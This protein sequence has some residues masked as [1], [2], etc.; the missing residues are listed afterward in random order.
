MNNHAVIYFPKRYLDIIFFAMAICTLFF[1]KAV[2]AEQYKLKLFLDLSEFNQA[3]TDAVWLDPLISPTNGGFFV[4]QDNGLI[5]LTGKD[6]KINRETILDLSQ[7]VN[8]SAFTSLT[9]ITLHP[10]FM[11]PEQ[12]GYATL[13]TAHTTDFSPQKNNNRLTLD[14]ADIDFSFETVITAW[15]YDFDDQ[16]I[17]QQTQREVLRIPIKNLD[18]AIQQLTFDP[19]QKSW[20]ADYGQLHFSLKYENELKDHPLYSGAILRI[21]PL[22]FGARNYTVPRTNPFIKDPKINNEI[23]VLGGQNI[24]HFFWAKN[25]HGVIFIQHNNIEEYRLSKAKVGDNLLNP[26]QS[27]LLWQQTSAMSSML[28]YQGRNFLSL[29]NKMVFFKLL[30]NQWYLSSLALMPL[31]NDLPVFEKLI[32][33][34]ALSPNSHLN[35]HQDNRGEIILFDNHKSKMYSLQSTHSNE[36]EVNISPSNISP[37]S[38]TNYVLYISVLAG[39]SIFLIFVYRKKIVQKGP[40]SL[41]NKNLVRFQYQPTTQT[42]LLFRASQKKAQKTLSIVD[43][44]RCEILLNNNVINII[45]DQ[46]DNAISNQTEVDIRDLFVDEHSNKMLDEQ[47][48]RIE[49][50]LSNKDNSYT[51]CLYL[52]KGSSRLTAYKYYEVID[53]L[54]DLCWVISKRINPGATEARLIPVVAKAAASIRPRVVPQLRKDGNIVDIYQPVKS[55]A[56]SKKS[57]KIQAR[58]S[59]NVDTPMLQATHQTKVVDALEKLASLHQKGHLSNEEFTLAKTKLLQNILDN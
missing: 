3:D 15:Q 8:N 28:L 31:N 25:N 5:Y 39:L 37:V 2:F 44:L 17:D 53:M 40:I 19:Y 18:M 34:E 57:E 33:R 22:V 1:T 36:T 42:I 56:T 46:P 41:L 13:Y 12:P 38:S 4:A 21:Y 11:R 23:V 20:S 35:I 55:I 50:I 49:M 43:V 32:A 9:A 16:K 10:S 54:I 52:R 51:V 24:N 27:H 14:D 26:S 29:R 59:I 48:R 30:D 45:N 6:G 7:M 47:S 58:D